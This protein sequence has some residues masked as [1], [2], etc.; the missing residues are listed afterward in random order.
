MRCSVIGLVLTLTA[1]SN[2]GFDYEEAVRSEMRDPDSA[3]FSNVATAPGVACGFVNAKNAYGGYVGKM[4]F[5]ATAPGDGIPTVHLIETW[6]KE[7]SNLIRS[8]C[9]ADSAF[10]LDM[11]SMN[12]RSDEIRAWIDQNAKSLGSG[13]K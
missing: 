5:V 10:D 7:N 13:T 8:R 1:C 4:I 3:E 12:K 9:P 6:T 11:W 2:A